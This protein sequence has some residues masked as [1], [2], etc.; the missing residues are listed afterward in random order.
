MKRKSGLHKKVS[1]IFEGTSLLGDDPSAKIPLADNDAASAAESATKATDLPASDVGGRTAGQQH[2]HYTPAAGALH[3][4]SPKVKPVLTE[5]QE[6]ATSQRRKLFMVIGLCVVFALVL[7][8]NFYQPG[9][10][11]TVTPVEP[12]APAVPVKV[13]QIHWP[14]PELWPEDIRDPMVF[15]EDAVKLYVV[16]QDMKG[17]F[18]LRGIVHKP[19][20]GSM[21]LLGTEILYEGDEIDGWTIKEIFHNTVRLENADGEKQELKMEDR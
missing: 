10:E 19:E 18:T 13:L 20:G 8:F 6:Y 3:K 2:R 21:A 12:S 1:S 11:T 17:P 7:F 5:D 16:E 4:T 9:K 15:K 14:E